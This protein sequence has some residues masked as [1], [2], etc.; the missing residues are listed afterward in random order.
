VIRIY[1]GGPV[2]RFQHDASRRGALAV[3]GRVSHDDDTTQFRL[4]DRALEGQTRFGIFYELDIRIPGIDDFN[5]QPDLL[6][7]PEDAKFHRYA[8]TFFLIAEVIS[9]SNRAEMIERKLELYRSHPENLYSITI[10]Q[11]SV[12]VVV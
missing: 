3:G 7:I 4:L 5:P 11:S 12:H 6:I 2:P 10:D 9:R 1:D 8:D